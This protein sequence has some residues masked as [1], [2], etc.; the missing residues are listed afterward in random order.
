[1]PDLDHWD[2]RGPVRTVDVQRTWGSN[3][4]HSIVE[5]RPDGAIS[6]RWHRNPDNSEWTSV[7]TYDDAGRLVSIRDESSAGEVHLR[8]HEYD[9][10]GRLM[11]HLS[12]DPSGGERIIESYSY[13]AA[14]RKTK[15]HFVDTASQ[16]P[17]TNYSW[18][19]EGSKAFYSAP[20][21]AKL[22]TAYDPAGRPNEFLF[23]DATGALTSRVDFH[24]DESGNLTE[25]AQT[26]TV[27]PFSGF[28]GNLSPEQVE[29]V[30]AV[31]SG[32]ISRRIHRYDALGHRIETLC[33]IFGSLGNHSETMEYN[34]HGD[35]ITQTSADESREYGFEEEGGELQSRPGH[36]SRSHARFIYEYDPRGNWTSKITEAGPGDN[37]DFAVTSTERR[38]LTYFD[39]I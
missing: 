24:Y 19:V 23:H 27:S 6:R 11:R 7:H 4:D 21:A 1:M 14:G 15:T 31:L 9:Q 39:P 12:R 35:L 33:S 22:A 34:Q 38:T 30:R 5:F 26:H 8:L 18:A 36:Q 13:D 32:P 28:E 3:G 25:E 29:A 16:R 37:P 20:N 10:L 17:N 2:L